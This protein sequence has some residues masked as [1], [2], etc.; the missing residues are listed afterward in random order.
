[1][2]VLNSMALKVMTSVPMSWDLGS[3]LQNAAKTL[4]TWGGYFIILIGVVMVVASVYQIA[5]GLISHGKGPGTNW[6]VAIALLILG[7]A[8]MTGGFAFVANIA[9]GGKKTINDLGQTVIPM[10]QIIF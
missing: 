7:G 10:L 5:K 6:A 2:D 8:F 9:G 1:M 4:K 3:F